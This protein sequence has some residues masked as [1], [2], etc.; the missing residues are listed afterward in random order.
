VRFAESGHHWNP[1][2][3]S[4]SVKKSASLLQYHLGSSYFSVHL[5]EN[6][7]VSLIS[8]SP[9]EFFRPISE[10][11]RVSDLAKVLLCEFN[12]ILY[13]Q[14]MHMTTDNPITTDDKKK[15]KPKTKNVSGNTIIL[16]IRNAGISTNMK[17]V[18]GL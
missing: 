9:Q 10:S 6:G 16:D 5:Y 2:A 12:P 7:R 4:L 11:A 13:I 15:G 1:I 3:V 8:G 14:I 18:K 17:R